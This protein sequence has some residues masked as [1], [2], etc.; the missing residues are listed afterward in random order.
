MVEQEIFLFRIKLV[1]KS[2]LV[3]HEKTSRYVCWYSHELFSNVLSV[4]ILMMMLEVIYFEESIVVEELT[5]IDF[6]RHHEFQLVVDVK[7]NFQSLDDF[8]V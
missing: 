2:V 4:L 8:V 5:A 7:I 1:T 6:H 3:E